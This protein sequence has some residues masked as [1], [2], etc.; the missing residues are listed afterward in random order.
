MI[1][2]NAAWLTAGAKTWSIEHAFL[3][4]NNLCH[5]ACS[6]D[7]HQ[8]GVV[9][10]IKTSKWLGQSRKGPSNAP[11]PGRGA[12]C[13][14]GAIMGTLE[15]RY[16]FSQARTSTVIFLNWM[17]LID[18]YEGSWNYSK[19][20][21]KISEQKWGINFFSSFFMYSQ[22]SRKLILQKTI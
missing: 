20:L 22:V 17:I 6:M 9:D 19:I 3:R 12:F 5:W 13:I 15:L 4:Y 14:S 8:Q 10:S 2:A 11:W 18:I 7:L 1:S 21:T 16:S